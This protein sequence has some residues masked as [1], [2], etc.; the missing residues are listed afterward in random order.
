V[1]L[2]VTSQPKAFSNIF[3]GLVKLI[4]LSWLIATNQTV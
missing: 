1:I 3:N 2:A 4:V